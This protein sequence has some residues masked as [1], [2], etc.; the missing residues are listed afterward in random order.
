MKSVLKRITDEGPLMAKDFEKKGGKTGEWQTKPVKQALENLYMQG[1]LMIPYRKN[2]LNIAGFAL[3][4]RI[5]TN[6]C[7]WG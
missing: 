5:I 6:Q 1:E 3:H 4:R 7:K 2:F